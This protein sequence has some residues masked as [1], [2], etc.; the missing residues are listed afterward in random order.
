MFSPC[1]NEYVLLSIRSW[2]VRMDFHLATTFVSVYLCNLTIFK[3]IIPNL[4]KEN[5]WRKFSNQIKLS[6][7]FSMRLLFSSKSFLQ[8]SGTAGHFV[9][10]DRAGC[11]LCAQVW[12][13]KPEMTYT[14]LFPERVPI[15]LGRKVPCLQI[16]HSHLIK[17]NSRE[18]LLGSHLE[19]SSTVRP[20]GR[21]TTELTLL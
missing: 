2:E 12:A 20:P 10:L 9:Q 17:S 1:Y 21:Q 3:I 15:P 4:F 13:P 18:S 6:F 7:L 19:F 14:P 11:P 8:L 5:N 16:S